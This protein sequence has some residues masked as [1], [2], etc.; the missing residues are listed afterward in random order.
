M[1]A[2]AIP[3]LAPDRK[4][5]HWAVLASAFLL[6][7]ALAEGAAAQSVARGDL[8]YTVRN[9]PVEARASNA[10]AA[11]E[12]AVADGQQAAFRSLLK[13]IVPVT[14]YSRLARLRATNAANLI[15]G[16]SVRSER[17]SSTDY[18]ATYDFAFQAE[19]VRRLLDKENISFLDR[20]A[21]QITLVPLYHLPA[22]REVA[23]P[24]QSSRGSDSWLYAWK[25][26]DLSNTLTP[27]MLKASTVSIDAA[28]AKALMNGEPGPLRNLAN[29]Y[30]TDT[31]VVALM[32]PDPAQRKVHVT[33]VGRDAV[34]NFI[35]RR[36]YRLDG[37]D[38]A[39]T[40]ELAAV[41]SL[42]VLEGR[43]KAINLR[44]GGAR[45]VSS[46][47][48]AAPLPRDQPGTAARPQPAAFGD[49]PIR[50]SVEFQSMG[51]WQDI[52]RRVSA[53]PEV[54]DL[55]VAGLSGRGAR[56]TLRYPG[57]PQDL[58]LALAQQGL[59]LRSAGGNWILTAR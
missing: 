13:R 44:R 10:V 29:E 43:W 6:S 7:A 52:S 49:G 46:G 3:A 59:I 15:D 47:P 12:R 17:N 36:S 35:L 58:A 28:T 27:I 55:D 57:S 39:Y 24:F 1:P 21:P 31:L 51:E 40:A 19:A 38:L 20:Q 33:L 16:V 30:K 42:G 37:P 5:R 25:G 18:I 50:I 34:A 48:A 22:G 2:T 32:E 9:Y 41:V 4:S 14:E 26:L 45:S 56:L 53:T 54:S 11:K 23:E 8:P